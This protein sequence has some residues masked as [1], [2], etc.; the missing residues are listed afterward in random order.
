MFSTKLEFAALTIGL[1]IVIAPPVSASPPPVPDFCTGQAMAQCEDY[2][3]TED[4]Y[5]CANAAYINCVN[6]NPQLYPS[7]DPHGFNT[8]Y[9]EY[10]HF[11]QGR[12]DCGT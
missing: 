11:C 4:Y 3:G 6:D 9:W 1:G 2:Y 5:T 7:G 10:Y 12:I 8:E